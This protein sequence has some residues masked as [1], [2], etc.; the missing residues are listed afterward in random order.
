MRL[1]IQLR[2]GNRDGTTVPVEKG[3]L[4]QDHSDRIAGTGQ[5]RQVGPTGSL[6]Q[7]GQVSLER[8]EMTGLPGHDSDVR[9]AVANVAQAGQ[10]EQE[11]S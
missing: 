3:H 5:S 11:N 10:L 6:E 9:R 2:Q 8:A 7:P 4:G 1:D